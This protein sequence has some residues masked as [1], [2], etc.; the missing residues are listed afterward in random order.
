[1][2]GTKTAANRGAVYTTIRGTSVA[3]EGVIF[4]GGVQVKSNETFTNCR[5]TENV[6]TKNDEGYATDGRFCMFI[7][8]EYDATGEWVVKLE[9]CI[10]NA[11][12][13]GCVK[14]AGDKGAK[15]T[16]DVKGCTFTN[17]CPSNNWS[18]DVP[19]YDVKATGDNIIVNDL[20][21]NTWAK[22]LAK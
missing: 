20:G 21:G 22:G 10:F 2:N 4:D 9:N 14:V 7:D 11:S 13:Y 18:K 17:T 5:F 15:I 16:V 1:M 8:H 19:K 6:L 3:Y 12:G